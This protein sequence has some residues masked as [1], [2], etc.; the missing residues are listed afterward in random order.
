MAITP[1][2]PAAR[3]TAAALTPSRL[4]P[5]EREASWSVTRRPSAPSTTA[6]QAAPQSCSSI[7]GTTGVR[8]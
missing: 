8:R 4:T 7:C 2:R 3:A 1:Y 5:Q 6:R